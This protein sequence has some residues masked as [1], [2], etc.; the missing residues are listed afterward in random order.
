[1]AISGFHHYVIQIDQL[2]R[3]SVAAGGRYKSYLQRNNSVREKIIGLVKEK[4]LENKLRRISAANSFNLLFIEATDEIIGL[5]SNV[6][7]IKQI[8]PTDDEP[9]FELIA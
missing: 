4:H 8:F 5:I 1:M 7:G 3:P 6:A 2:E 9:M